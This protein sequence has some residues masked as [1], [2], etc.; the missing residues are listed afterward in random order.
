MPVLGKH[1]QFMQLRFAEWLTFSRALNFDN[2]TRTGHDEICIRARIGIFGV[3]K[4]RH[5]HILV[6]AAG[7]G[8]HI[9]LQWPFGEQRALF[10]AFE[11]IIKCDP[12]PGDRGRARATIGLQH[13]T[14]QGDLAFAQGFQG[15]QRRARNAR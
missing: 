14:V 8:G 5:G 7:Q 11:A 13:V 3:I 10:H 9:V 2:A 12:S 4:V 6:D 15:Q 1:Q